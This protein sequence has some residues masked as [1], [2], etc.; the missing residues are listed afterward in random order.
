M[1]WVFTAWYSLDSWEE[2]LHLSHVQLFV[3]VVF[4]LSRHQKHLLLFCGWFFL[5]FELTSGH[6]TAPEE[7]SIPIP[8]W[9]FIIIL[10]RSILGKITVNL[11]PV[12]EFLHQWSRWGTYFL[13]LFTG[14]QLD[15]GR[16]TFLLF[17]VSR[18]KYLENKDMNC[19][20]LCDCRAS[21]LP[22]SLWTP[23][24]SFF[25]PPLFKCKLQGGETSIWKIKERKQFCYMYLIF[26]LFKLCLASLGNKTNGWV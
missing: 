4:Y 2:C 23:F 10:D 14:K 11:L 25:F 21:R 24:L 9:I 19:I 17:Q 7:R 18:T 22:K 20:L 16:E 1:F 12:P 5:S 3:S 13:L 15:A 6:K 8:T 26:F